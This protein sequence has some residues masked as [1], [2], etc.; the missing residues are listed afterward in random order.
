MAPTQVCSARTK[1]APQLSAT[2]IEASTSQLT[3]TLSCRSGQARRTSTQASVMKATVSGP[4][5][6]PLGMSPMFCTCTPV[7]PASRST[8]A[9]ATAAATIA[10]T[11][12]PA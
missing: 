7:K 4:A 12:S 10:A 9:C 3:M 1:S 5:R 6:R 2:A 11:G 8:S